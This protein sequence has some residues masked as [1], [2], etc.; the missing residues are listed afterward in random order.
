MKNV[1][2][3]TPRDCFA[4]QALIGLLALT[5][6]PGG[7]ASLPRMSIADD[8]TASG[9]NGEMAHCRDENDEPATFAQFLAGEAYVL[10]QEREKRP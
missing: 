5:T 6:Q 4:G 2:H 7:L 9:W 8:V 3:P 10:M 1:E